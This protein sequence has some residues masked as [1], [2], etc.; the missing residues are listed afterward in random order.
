MNILCTLVNVYIFII[1]GRIILSWFP[2]S[3]GVLGTSFTGVDAGSSTDLGLDQD[4]SLFQV[5]GTDTTRVTGRDAPTV[6]GAVFFHRLFW[7][8]RANHFFNG[9]NIWGNADP[10]HPAVLERLSDGSLGEVAILLDN[11]AAASQA[12]RKSF[13]CHSECSTPRSRGPKAT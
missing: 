1:F 12:V 10:N 13:P 2:R 6:I 3:S 11:A 9:R 5:A 8:G 4:D 7:D